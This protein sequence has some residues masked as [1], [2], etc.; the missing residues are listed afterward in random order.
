MD[1]DRLL[2]EARIGGREED[3]VDIGFKDGRIAAIGASL[4]GEGPQEPLGGRLVL[5]GF[6]ETHIHLDKSCLLGRCQ[7]KDGT[8]E[9]AI[10][11][12]AQAKRGFTVD[13]VYERASRTLE[14][15]IL[16]GTMR[17]R[18][19][20]EVDPRVG[21][22]SLYALL[23]LRQ[24][25]AWAIDLQICAFPQEGLLDD[26]GCEQVI[27]NALEQGADVIGGS[28]T[29][30]R[31][32]HGQI[33]RIFEIARRFDVDIDMHIDFGLDPSHLDVEEVCR[34]T[35]EF[36]WGGRVTV[37]HVTKMS[38]V[39]AARFAA[40][41]RRLADS[42][43]AVTVLPATDLYLNGHDY[44]CSEPRGLTAAHRLIEQGVTCSISTNNV[45]NP[46][47]PFGDCSLVRMA[48][49]YAT[50]THAGSAEE[51]A[52]CLDMVT[53]QSARLLNLPDYGIA[54]GNPAD[55]VVLDTHSRAGALSELAPVLAGFKGGARTFARPLPTLYRP[56]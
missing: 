40:L 4:D 19:H 13:D 21:L 22:T 31:D 7:C 44:E 50:V 54:V 49:L 26:P 15:S 9:E 51:M 8:V 14:K 17:M 56:Q 32:S 48:N 36:G 33:A 12:V 34:K 47:T 53:V 43:V 28:P 3:V 29:A 39:P 11:L 41:A 38:A 10:S 30:D 20:V 35:E 1:F 46:F 18:T 5:P 16:H 45:L 27:I 6:V 23:Q 55:L 24:D 37:G 25:Y 2:R 52:T 42:G